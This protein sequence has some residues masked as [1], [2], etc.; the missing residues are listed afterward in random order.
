MPML[1]H[2][3]DYPLHIES[4]QEPRLRAPTAALVKA[5]LTAVGSKV[6]SALDAS[7]RSRGLLAV[8][9]AT[10]IAYGKPFDSLTWT[11][12]CCF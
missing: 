9:R 1:I 11:L 10:K 3:R 5:L 4:L 2:C 7:A 8:F 6:R 12:I